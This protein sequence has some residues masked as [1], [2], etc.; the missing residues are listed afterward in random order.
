MTSN[1]TIRPYVEADFQQLSIVYLSAFAE[2]PWDEYMKCIKCGINY[3]IKEVE[4][5][6]SSCKKCS[7]KL[8]LEYFWSPEEIK[9]D[10]D[11][12]LSKSSNIIL[13]ADMGGELIGTVWGYEIPLDK[14]PFL[15]GIAKEKANY[16]DEI[17]V[18]GNWRMRGLGTS[19]GT[20]YLE[21]LARKNIPEVILRTDERNTASMGLFCK[22]GF[23]NTGIRDPQ[24]DWRV[25]LRRAI[26]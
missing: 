26:S 10:L 4:R 11:F 12:A 18:K 23:E 8:K 7:S 3:G 21:Q 14:F 25:Y 2:P 5:K 17:A 6:E 15:R 19:L 1:L 22:L 20:E 24:F 16:M 13:V 9:K